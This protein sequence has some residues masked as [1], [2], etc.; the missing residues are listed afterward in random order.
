MFK[1]WPHLYYKVFNQTQ[2]EIVRKVV[3]PITK[4]NI[5]SV[6][7]N[8]FLYTRKVPH[9]FWKEDEDDDEEMEEDE[10]D[11]DFEPLTL[12]EYDELSIQDKHIYLQN[13]GYYYGF[14]PE[15]VKPSEYKRMTT[16][17]KKEYEAEMR[18]LASPEFFD[19]FEEE[20]EILEK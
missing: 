19:S 2:R 20:V 16:E 1:D 17:E 8:T 10:D 18:W 6:T 3:W 5:A 12:E 14:D 11:E 4:E 15:L 9:K 13:L 7:D